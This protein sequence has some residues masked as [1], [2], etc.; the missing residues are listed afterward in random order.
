MSALWGDMFDSIHVWLDYLRY[1][2]SS[3]FVLKVLEDCNNTPTNGDSGTVEG[4][5]IVGL[6]CTFP[7]VLDRGT[8]G[9]VVLK[10]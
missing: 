4:V 10:I 3:L 5:H 6:P 9:L 1:E 7:P 2:D 8:T